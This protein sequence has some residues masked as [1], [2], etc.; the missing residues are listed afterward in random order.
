MPLALVNVF[1]C[2]DHSAFPLHGPVHP[3][4][5][6]P[7]RIFE[8]ESPPPMLPVFKPVP[9]VLPPQF[10]ALN[11]PVCALP[12]SLISLPYALVFVP[13]LVEHNTKAFLA[14]VFPVAYISA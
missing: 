13:I 9:S 1:V 7:V 11:P 14:I 12:V 4:P 2:V 3:V 6:V 8:E 10:A 5:I